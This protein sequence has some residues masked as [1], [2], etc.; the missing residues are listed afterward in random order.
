MAGILAVSPC[1]MAGSVVYAEETT[2]QE[3]TEENVVKEGENLEENNGTEEKKTQE[4]SETESSEQESSVEENA[5]EETSTEETSSEEEASEEQSVEEG[6][7]EEQS[8]EEEATEEQSNEEEASEEET[9]EEEASTEIALEETNSENVTLTQCYGK[10]LAFDSA[11]D[12]DEQGEMH[13]GLSTEKPLKSGATV[14]FDLY[15]P[16]ESADFNGTIKAQGV[17]RVGSNWAWTENKSIPEF[18]AANLIET[19]EVDG[20]L[21]KKINISY[22]FGEELS[23]DYLANFTVKLAGWMCNYQGSI[24]YANV[25][26]DGE[27]IETPVE[28]PEE[29]TLVVPEGY[30]VFYGK[31]LAFDNTSEWDDKGE[32]QLGLTS[33]K[34]LNSGAKVSFDVILPA[35]ATFNGAIKVQG[36]AR[37]GD[38]WTWTQNEAIPEYSAADFAET[39]EIEGKTYK[40]ANVSFTF[41]EEIEADYLAEFTVKLAGWQCDYEGPVYYANVMLENGAGE[42]ASNVLQLWDFATGL[43]GWYYDGTWDND[44]ENSVEWN[45]QYQALQMNVDY[46]KNADSTWSEIMSSFWGDDFKVSGVNKLTFDFIYDSAK[47]TKG[48][49]KSKVFSNSGVNTDVTINLESA[50]DYDGTLKKVPVSFT[51]DETDIENGITIGIIGYETDYQGAVYLDNVTLISEAVEVEDIYVDAIEEVTGQNMQLSVQGNTLVTGAGSSEIA[52]EITLVDADATDDVKQIYAYLQAVG[53][54]DSVIFGQQNNTSHKA[55]NANLS[56]SDTMDVVGS[57]TGVIGLDGLSLTGN[58]YSAERYLNEM[59]GV[60]SAYDSA[61]AKIAQAQTTIEQNVIAA[62]A[63]TNY[64]IRNG[65]IATLSLHTPNLSKVDTVSA[66]AEAPSYAAYDFSGYTPGDLSGDVMNNILTGGAYNEEFTAYLDMVADYAKQ[67]DGAI[68]FRPFHENTG[69]WFWWGAALCDAQTYKSVYKYTVEYLRDEKGVHNLLYV[70]GPGA[71][72]ANVEEYAERYPGDGYVDMVGFDMYH[73]NPAQGDAFITN[74]IKELSVVESFA[75]AHGKLVAVTETGTRHDTVEG[76]NQT[77]MLKQGNARPD[78]H[79]EILDAV[80]AS[81]ASYYL[82]WANFSEKDGFYT[83]YVKSVN[84]EG[85]KHGHEMMDNFIRFFNQDTSVFAVNQKNALEQMKSVSIHA[86]A[87]LEH[88]GYIVSP[89]AGTRVLEATTLTAKVSGV[90]EED[91]VEFVCAGETQTRTLTAV[92]ANGYAVAELTSEDLAVM[93]EYVGS[94]TLQI[95]GTATETISV[96]F[97][98]PEPVADPY[99]IDGFENYYGVDSQLTKAWTTNKASGSS[100]TL[101]LAQDNVNEGDYAMEFN[102]N[103]T[104]DGWAGATISKEVSWADCD[105]LSFWTIP[106]GNAQKTVIQITANGNVYEYYMNLNED[107]VAASTNAVYVT[108][109]FA[110]FVARDITGNPAGGLVEDKGSITSFGLWVNAIGDSAAVVDGMVSGTIYYDSITAVSAG[111]DTAKVVLADSVEPEKPEK[112]GSS[113]NSNHGKKDKHDQEEE[114][115]VD[116][117]VFPTYVGVDGK[118]VKGWDKVV[119]SAYEMAEL[120]NPQV[121]LAGTPDAVVQRLTVDINVTDVTELVIPKTAITK[122]IATGADYNFFMGDTVITL[123]S[124][125]LAGMKEELDLKLYERTVTDF[126][127]GLDAKFISSRTRMQFA[128]QTNMNVVLGKEE[129][130]KPAY[131]YSYNEEAHTYDFLAAQTVSE[132][133]TVCISLDEYVSCLILY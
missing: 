4:S 2:V 18:T 77:A 37:L 68:L 124:E 76:D 30:S 127:A 112:P 122:M 8:V 54:T 115:P 114:K 35:D 110:E 104:S 60:D 57:Y 89:I 78:W 61:V 28:T 66:P 126:G 121:P 47:L 100:I 24:Y 44:G 58:E 83:P 129:A 29:D 45:E 93:G 108:I 69:S 84:E 123:S 105:A 56:N 79:Q 40:K 25:E 116:N 14:S 11:S 33:E 16:E 92:V 106:D 80:K 70:Y 21:Y 46:S 41:G 96:M 20:Q 95:N 72:A 81:D 128:Q 109:P 130:G 120:N 132:I 51:F 98:I 63:L 88:D 32:H 43:D 111:L 97:N 12:W 5:S 48:A 9:T 73:D 39:V 103:E 59:A 113:N 107:Y 53:K 15:I 23:A 133:G 102:Y 74:F 71:E 1:N 91:T 52:Q 82:V 67:V 87:A 64:N 26:L 7:T 90:T 38:N 131:I 3:E 119:A 49:F 27:E 117:R 75:K 17:A 50:E 118:K 62:A 85:T 42:V 94:I 55:G 34:A 6:A 99:E 13:L 65:A 22:I 101:S 10:E 19:V 125:I 36:I 86:T 31:E